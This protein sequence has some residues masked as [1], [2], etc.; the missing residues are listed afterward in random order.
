MTWRCAQ[1]VLLLLIGTGAIATTTTTNEARGL[2]L[3]TPGQYHRTPCPCWT[4]TSL[5]AALCSPALAYTQASDR[6]KRVTDPTTCVEL[7]IVEGTDVPQTA[8]LRYHGDASHHGDFTTLAT[9]SIGR[10]QVYECDARALVS[11]TPQDVSFS[12]LSSNQHESCT[13]LFDQFSSK[14]FPSKPTLQHSK[15]IT[16]PVV[17]YCDTLEDND[18]TTIEPI[19]DEEDTIGEDPETSTENSA[20]AWVPTWA[21]WVAV[22]LV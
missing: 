9:I 3:V 19:H 4:N 15:L 2:I 10:H 14:Y 20:Q 12:D 22:L 11:A 8:T 13:Y 18:T 21:M 5:F 7:E 17:S 6:C 16:T 1:G